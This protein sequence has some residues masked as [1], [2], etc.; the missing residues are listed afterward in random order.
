M[1]RSL[2]PP[3]CVARHPS[4]RPCLELAAEI[5]HYYPRK[6]VTIVQGAGALLNSTYP[7]KFRDKVAKRVRDMGI[8]VILSEKII[9]IPPV[10][11]T[12]GP[13]SAKTA[14]NLELVA[15]LFVS[16]V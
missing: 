3:S 12:I 11:M 6:T 14:K 7:D 4:T 13:A 8:N 2:L 16:L 15:D 10:D 1:V 9:D 5:K